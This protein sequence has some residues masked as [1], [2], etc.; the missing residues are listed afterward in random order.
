MKFSATINPGTIGKDEVA[1]LKLM[2]EN[3]GSV[4]QITPPSLN[5]FIVI[6]GPNQESGMDMINGT[7]RQYIGITYLLKPKAKGD[8]IIGTAS[9]KADG[10][11]WKS[12]AVQLKVVSGTTG[13]S[14]NRNSPFSSMMPFDEPKPEP[15]Y[16]DFILKKGENLQDKISRNLFIKVDADKTSCYVGEPVVVTYKLYTRLKSESNIVKNPSF[17]GFSV[18]DLVQPQ[19]AI[20]YNVEKLNGRDYNVYTLRKVQLYPL[21]QG[22]AELEMAAIE[23]RVHF[24]KGE[25]LQK[26]AATDLFGEFIPGTVPAD[27]MLNEKVTIQSKPLEIN[28]KPLP[29]AG[30]PASFN[31]AVGNFTVDVALEKDSLT[32]DDAGKLSVLLAGDGNLTLIPA[33]EIAWPQ[34]LEGYEPTVKDGLNKASV[35][36]SGSKI[37]DYPFTFASEGVYTIPAVEF[38]FF[39]VVSGKYKVVIT[40]PITVHVKK[41]TGKKPAI[42][43]VDNRSRKESFFEM[44]FTNRWM[45]I[46]PVAL[47]IITGLLIWLKA[48]HK[49]QQ[50]KIVPV[51]KETVEEKIIPDAVLHCPL[52]E[53]EAALVNN[54][55]RKFYETLNKE[56]H[57][58]LAI[59]LKLAPENISK[60]TIAD[61]LD[62]AGVGVGDSFAVQQLLDDVSLQLYTPFAD[63]NKMQDCFAEAMRLVSIFSKTE[64]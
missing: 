54:D 22:A 16:D 6:S 64:L 7:T 51:V 38:S 11:N 32:T 27:A 48:D 17:N 29:D 33:P 44:I 35:P 9:A 47:L 2:V 23:N 21:Q 24:I 55:A 46:V 10:K 61:G 40:N 15:N 1:E 39:D 57:V 18:I 43:A 60:R 28:V 53:T 45:I 19:A 34:G 25:Y 14:A 30:K 31:G 41:G 49:K 4:E 3:A 26:G 56:L 62:K 13:N 12:N 59:K 52:A 58:F 20:N 37:F 42:V 63:E 8:F 36:V 50:Q 5:N